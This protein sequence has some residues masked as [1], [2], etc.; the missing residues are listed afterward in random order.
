MPPPKKTVV[1]SYSSYRPPY[2]EYLPE[3]K[4]ET[5]VLRIKMVGEAG[6]GTGFT[7]KLPK[8]PGNVKMQVKM[9]DVCYKADGTV[10]GQG[11]KFMKP[12][13]TTNLYSDA[14]SL[15]KDAWKV[16]DLDYTSLGANE[17]TDEFVVFTWAGNSQSIIEVYISYIIVA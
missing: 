4:G 8:D 17:K 5:G 15:T 2:V 12:G 11:M 6:G 9:Y 7:L 16:Y 3:Y 13:T 10:D 14:V 1:T